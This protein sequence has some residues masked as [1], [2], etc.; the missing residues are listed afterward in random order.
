MNNIILYF[1][2]IFPDIK[3]KH[4]TWY[5]SFVYKVWSLRISG[6]NKKYFKFKRCY[7]TDNLIIYRPAHERKKIQKIRSKNKRN[8]SRN[9]CST[10]TCKG[11]SW[12]HEHF[13]N[14]SWH[15]TISLF[16]IPKLYMEYTSIINI[17]LTFQ[18]FWILLVYFRFRI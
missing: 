18:L 7:A 9:N 2:S 17:R 3:A 4:D 11:L 12:V 10:L 13:V 14:I 15:R 6:K 16:Y 5:N 1:A 8:E